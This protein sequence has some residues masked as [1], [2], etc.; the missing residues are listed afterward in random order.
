MTPAHFGADPAVIPTFLMSRFARS[1]IKVALS[2]EGSD[3]IFGG[4]PTYIGAG[5]AEY[6]LRLPQFVRG[7]LLRRLGRSLPA[8]SGAVPV[9]MFLRRF[10]ENAEREVEG[11][12]CRHAFGKCCDRLTDDACAALP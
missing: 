4:Y 5:L 9:G 7:G 12:A 10:L 2:G 6:Y 8:S 1:E 3:E 11:D